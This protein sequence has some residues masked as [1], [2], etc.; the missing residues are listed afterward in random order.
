[1]GRKVNE[2]EYSAKDYERFNRRIHDQVDVL[3]EVFP[4]QIL[5]WMRYALALNSNYT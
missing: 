2:M 4:D 3:K 5:A 1:M